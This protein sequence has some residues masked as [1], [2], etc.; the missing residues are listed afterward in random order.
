MDSLLWNSFAQ[1]GNGSLASLEQHEG[2]SPAA[3]SLQALLVKLA[4]SHLNDLTIQNR[5]YPDLGMALGTGAT[6]SVERKLAQGQ[7]FVAVKHIIQDKLPRGG[8]STRPPISKNRLDSVLL[9]V[10]A[11]LHY[12]LQK[13]PNI[14][15][16][17]AYGWDDGGIPF[18]V[19]EYADLGSLD[20]FLKFHPT[21]WAMKLKLTL[22]IAS[23]LELLHGCDIVHGDIK[24]ENILVFSSDDG[25]LGKISDFGFCCSEALVNNFYHGTRILNA[26]ELRHDPYTSTVE[27]RL[28]YMACDTYSYGLLVWEVFNGGA[29]FFSA[30]SIGIN[31]ADSDR[32]CQ[33]LEQLWSNGQELYHFAVA[34]LRELILSPD[35]QELVEPVLQMT[36]LRDPEQRS[37][38]EEVRLQLDPNDK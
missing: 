3:S 12:P 13:H 29:R 38:M 17:L 37:T 4:C 27:S 34:F 20:S 31:P 22:D 30:S 25:P 21:S 33:F 6:F 5:L 7:I 24:L 11:L 15:D 19:V 36:L 14:V 1:S 18:L 10:Q 9:E 16:L 26:P 35:I 28:D 23:G 2:S 8:F 32:A